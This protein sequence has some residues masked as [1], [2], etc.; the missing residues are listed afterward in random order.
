MEK[1]STRIR[2]GGINELYGVPV[3]ILEYPYLSLGLPL[4]TMMAIHKDEMIVTWTCV[5]SC[6]ENVLFLERVQAALKKKI[7]Q[8]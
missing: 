6:P 7:H 4:K 2:Y 1:S 3:G 8:C 5:D